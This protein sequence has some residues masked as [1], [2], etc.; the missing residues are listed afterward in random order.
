MT[1]F[2]IETRSL[3]GGVWAVFFADWREDLS[4]DEPRFKVTIERRKDEYDEGG[5]LL[6]SQVFFVFEAAWNT[7]LHPAA[8]PQMPLDVLAA[9]A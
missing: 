8:S 2:E 5:E 9:V 6:W 3:G 1:V 4:E 7:Y